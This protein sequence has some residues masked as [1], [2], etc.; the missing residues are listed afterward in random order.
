[1]DSQPNPVSVER[2]AIHPNCCRGS[3]CMQRTGKYLLSLLVL[4]IVFMAGVSVGVHRSMRVRGAGWGAYERRMGSGM[5]FMH[6]GFQRIEM[7]SPYI[8]QPRQIQ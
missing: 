7:P 2:E 8:V 5:P 4:V 3:W 6:R 1:M